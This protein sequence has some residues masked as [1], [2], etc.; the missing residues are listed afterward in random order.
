MN[1]TIISVN[2]SGIPSIK[3]IDQLTTKDIYAFTQNSKS[4]L[5]YTWKYKNMY[6]HLFGSIDGSPRKENKFEVPP[7]VDT[8]LFFDSLVF[9]LSSSDQKP[10][11]SSQNIVNLNIPLFD[12]IYESLYGGFESIHDTDSEMSSEDEEY[13]DYEHTKEGYAKDGFVV[14]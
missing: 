2:T 4:D 13:Y 8:T 10:T 3:Y 5:I 12:S 9:V 11:I 1:K 7:P 14:D 6:L